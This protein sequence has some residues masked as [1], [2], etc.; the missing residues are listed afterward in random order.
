M[1]K[2]VAKTVGAP[3]GTVFA[4]TVRGKVGAA[5]AVSV[6]G[7]RGILLQEAPENPTAGASMDV[8]TFLCLCWGRST[9]G[10]ALRAGNLTLSGDHELAQA[11]VGAMNILF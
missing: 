8:E 10:Q 5:K 2:V 9:A 11:V 6:Q 4:F 7:G 1:P 3:E